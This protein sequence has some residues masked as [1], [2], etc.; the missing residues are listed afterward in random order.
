MCV[1]CRFLLQDVNNVHVS[2]AGI[3]FDNCQIN[4]NTTRL[5]IDSCKS[6]NEVEITSCKGTCG[7][8]S[9]M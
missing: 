2:F 7:A 4:R 1:T 5:Q 8:S 6:D 3:T 9:S